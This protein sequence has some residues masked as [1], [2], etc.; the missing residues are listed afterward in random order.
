MAKIALHNISVGGVADFDLA[1]QDREFVVLAGPAGCGSSTI[2]RVIAGLENPSRGDILF[3]ER[4]M[5]GIPP[6]DREV[7]VVAKDY[8]PYPRMSVYDNLAFA[9]RPG[10]FSA[11][12]TKKRV[13]A[14]AEVIGLQGILE[15]MPATLGGEERQ[16]LALARA[17]ARQ[18]KIILFDEPFASLDRE[19]RVRARAEIRKLHQ[20][21]PATTIIYATND[22]V[23]ALVMGERLVVLDQGVVQQEGDPAAVYDAP[24]NLFVAGFIGHPPMNLIHG[25]LKQDRDSLVFSEQGDGTIKVRLPASEFPNAKDFVGQPIVFGIRPEDI[26]VALAETERSPTSF[27][28]LVEMVEPM[29]AEANLYLQT[30]AHAVICRSRRGIDKGNAGHRL[31]FEI[32]IEKARLFDP[33]SGRLIMRE[34]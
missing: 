29:G 20:R 25:T 22:P 1:I 17:I 15:R 7:A 11:A 6:K 21:L 33:A 10:K 14:A 23:E 26:T 8:A 24:A 31:Q 32:D 30:G 2:L 9:L 19:A 12:E 13:L 27:R 3:D 28:A 16:R 5:N 34:G 4:R 18:P